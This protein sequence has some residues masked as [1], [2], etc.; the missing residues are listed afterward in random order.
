MAIGGRYVMS[1][2]DARRG[3]IRQRGVSDNSDG[4]CPLW[5]SQSARTEMF[6]ADVPPQIDCHQPGLYKDCKGKVFSS[7]SHG[8][9]STSSWIQSYHLARVR[10]TSSRSTTPKIDHLQV[11]LWSCSVSACKC[12]SKPTRSHPPSVSPNPL[13]HGLQVQMSMTSLCIAELTQSQSLSAS[14]SSL[15]HGLQVYVQIRWITG[16]KCISSHARSRPQSV[17]PSSLDRHF[18]AH[19]KFLSSTSCSQSGYTVCRWVAI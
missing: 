7:H 6:L 4:A 5:R 19:H 2:L 18:H 17:S 14:L 1:G 8:V 9:E 15:D 3:V 11:L 10:S 16:S 12:I 13:D